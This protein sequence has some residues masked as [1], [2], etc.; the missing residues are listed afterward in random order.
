MENLGK[1]TDASINNKIQEIQNRI[2]GLKD[3]IEE[4]ESS[5]KEKAKSNQRLKQNIQKTW[6]TMKRPK[7]RIIGIEE[8]DKF[9]LKTIEENFINLKQDMPVKI[10]K[11]YRR[12]NRWDQKKIVLV[13]Q[14][15]K[16]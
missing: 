13:P 7:I 2:S 5:V 3:T 15:I 14:T 11:D 1:H 12:P 4:I 16:H 9:Q 10:Q 6:D 8:I